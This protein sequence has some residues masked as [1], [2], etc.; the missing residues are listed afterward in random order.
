MK[1]GADT[2]STCSVYHAKKRVRGAPDQF[3]QQYGLQYHKY[4]VVRDKV[5]K[6]PR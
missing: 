3:I 4:V 1:L 2:I 5:C 6:V